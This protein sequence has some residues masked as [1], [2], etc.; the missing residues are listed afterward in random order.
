[1]VQLILWLN[2]YRKEIKV[3]GRKYT[4]SKKYTKK[5]TLLN[6]IRTVFTVGLLVLVYF[7]DLYERNDGVV[8]WAIILGVQVI[9]LGLFYL[10]FPNEI[11]KM[12]Q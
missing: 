8:L 4:L 11:E 5:L 12:I 9:F 1:M 3:K 2:P 7:T 10:I 6:N